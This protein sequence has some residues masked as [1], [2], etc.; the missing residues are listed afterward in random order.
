MPIRRLLCTAALV[1]VAASS[2]WAIPITL[3]TTAST[4]PG[5]LAGDA[6]AAAAAR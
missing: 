3:N 2:G 4:A 1:F 6:F 5:T